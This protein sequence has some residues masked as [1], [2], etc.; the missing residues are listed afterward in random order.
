M[1]VTPKT[2]KVT[3]PARKRN[4]GPARQPLSKILAGIRPAAY[5]RR[6][7]ELCDDPPVGREAW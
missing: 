7:R 1:K 4:A 6:R 3:A 2:I 5:R